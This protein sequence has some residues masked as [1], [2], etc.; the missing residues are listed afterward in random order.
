MSEDITN[1]FK[2]VGADVTS[3]K[4]LEISCRLRDGFIYFIDS[5]SK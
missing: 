4:E 5:Q 3:I 1:S 2:M